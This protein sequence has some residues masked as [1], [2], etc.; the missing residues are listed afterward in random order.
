[1]A[2][3]TVLQKAAIRRA[4]ECAETLSRGIAEDGKCELHGDAYDYASL[5]LLEI[6]HWLK[7][8][9]EDVEI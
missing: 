3:L 5:E 8:I 4:K 2:E 1:M 9:L 6:Q 7:E